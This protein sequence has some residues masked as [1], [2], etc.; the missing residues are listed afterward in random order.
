MKAQEYIRSKNLSNESDRDIV[1]ILW[2]D[3][4]ISQTDQIDISFELFDRSPEYGI[5]SELNMAYKEMEPEI[6]KELW[7]KYRQY[8]FSGTQDQKEQIKYSLWVDF[9]EDPKTVDV[10]WNEMIDAN[11]KIEIIREV[12][13]VSGPVPFEKK[14]E[15]YSEVIADKR[16][17]EYILES[18]VGSL[19]NVFGQIHFQKSREILPNLDVDRKTEK[20][21]KF[22]DHLNRFNTKRELYDYLKKEKR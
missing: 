3:E 12:L 7:S 9:F 18:L 2:Y 19:Y 10:A 8:L 11:S 13:S 21:R 5:V 20:Y 1:G 15:L 22:S 4:H 6:K 14:E 17:H 16:N